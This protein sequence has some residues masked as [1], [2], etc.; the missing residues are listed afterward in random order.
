VVEEVDR[1]T[2]R[3]EDGKT[4]REWV[5]K[6]EETC[7]EEWFYAPR[8]YSFYKIKKEKRNVGVVLS[9]FPTSRLSDFILRCN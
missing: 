1:K 7:S 9:D 5:E 4:G 3:P 2:G 8:I 6:I